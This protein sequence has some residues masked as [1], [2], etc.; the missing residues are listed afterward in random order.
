M[1]AVVGPSPASVTQLRRWIKSRKGWDLK[2]ME[3]G[4][5]CRRA[6]C[7][8]GGAEEGFGQRPATLASVHA[9]N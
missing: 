5:C 6:I 2:S 4:P 9:A 7:W 3:S 8:V 1:M